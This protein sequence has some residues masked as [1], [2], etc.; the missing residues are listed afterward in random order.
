MKVS[1]LLKSKNQDI[2]FTIDPHRAE[3]I[4]VGVDMGKVDPIGWSATNNS[5]VIGVRSQLSSV[6]K[7]FDTLMERAFAETLNLRLRC[8]RIT[9]GEIYL[10]PIFE[11]DDTS[12]KANRVGFKKKKVDVPKF[13]RMFQSI[14]DLRYYEDPLS[15]Y[16]YNATALVV[17]DFSGPD[18]D[19]LWA[20]QDFAR[21]Y[22]GEAITAAAE[23]LAPSLFVQ[24]IVDAYLEAIAANSSG[25]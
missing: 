12:L 4:E 18:V 2:A 1:G 22:P 8:P 20:P 7:N 11:F 21:V 6:E 25:E 9:L 15:I 17:A 10:I 5:L 13:L 3:T 24:K 23:M 16:K 19:V 14:T